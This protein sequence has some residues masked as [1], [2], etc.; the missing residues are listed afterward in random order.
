[1]AGERCQCGCKGS[2]IADIDDRGCLQAVCAMH[3]LLLVGHAIV[4]SSGVS[5]IS[6]LHGQ[7]SVKS[8]VYATTRV[9]TGIARDGQILWR[10]WFTLVASAA[11][12]LSCCCGFFWIQNT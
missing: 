10:D 2:A 3:V 7:S 11:T 1:M 5:D 8:L 9:L 6:N 4:D 12:G